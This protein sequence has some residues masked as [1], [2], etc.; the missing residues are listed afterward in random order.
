MLADAQRQGRLDA[1]L[2]KLQRVPL[3]IVDEVGYIPCNALA[4]S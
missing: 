2:D 3:L 1:E 4:S